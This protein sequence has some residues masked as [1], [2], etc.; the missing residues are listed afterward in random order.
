MRLLIGPSV[1]SLASFVR[2]LVVGM[3]D[4]LWLC[5]S[6]GRRLRLGWTWDLLLL[7]ISPL[8]RIVSIGATGFSLRSTI[9][10]SPLLDAAPIMGAGRRAATTATIRTTAI[11][12]DA[13]FASSASTARDNFQLETAVATVTTVVVVVA[14][15]LAIVARGCLVA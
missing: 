1:S 11:A 5:R 15:V 2:G 12:I 7:G 10:F 13:P 9:L 6:L 14:A 3:S 8:A 4:L